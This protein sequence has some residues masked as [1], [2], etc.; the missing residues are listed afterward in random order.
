MAFRRTN[1]QSFNMLSIYFAAL[2]YLFLSTAAVGSPDYASQSSGSQNLKAQGSGTQGNF[3]SLVDAFP[4]LANLSPTPDTGKDPKYGGQDFTHC[5][6]LAVN[7]S[8]EYD[9]A[10]QSIVKTNDWIQATV[11]ELLGNTSDEQFPCGA[12][13]NGDRQ[14]QSSHM[15]PISQGAVA[16][17]VMHV[18][19]SPDSNDVS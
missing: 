16:D 8:L 11:G 5:C 3:T 12:K 9:A 14:G 4:Q 10:N 15:S 17:K 19:I 7:Q 13:Y 6:L 2:S 18:I 1:L